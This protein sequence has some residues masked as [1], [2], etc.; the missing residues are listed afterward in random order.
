[1]GSIF[2]RPYQFKGTKIRLG[3]TLKSSHKCINLTKRSDNRSNVFHWKSFCFLPYLILKEDRMLSSNK[4]RCNTRLL[5][6]NL[7]ILLWL[8]Q[9]KENK[10]PE[11]H[12][13]LDMVLRLFNTLKFQILS[14]ESDDG[15]SCEVITWVKSSCSQVFTAA[16]KK[17]PESLKYN[18]RPE[19]Y[20]DSS[21]DVFL[22]VWPNI[23]E[24]FF[25]ESKKLFLVVTLSAKNHF[26]YCID[27]TSKML[28]STLV[29]FWLSLNIF[30]AHTVN[31]L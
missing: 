14:T 29:I 27:L 2:G 9:F 3:M 11:E 21:T 31:C 1:M 24:Y 23:S 22:W 8:K 7:E 5:K 19:A 30:R 4:A 16:Y 15:Q 10:F 17:T 12:H 18:C 28:H 26:L 13:A 20:K 6:P 25:C